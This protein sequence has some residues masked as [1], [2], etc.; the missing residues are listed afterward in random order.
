MKCNHPVDKLIQ[1]G[2]SQRQGE[3]L[4]TCVICGEKVQAR[5]SSGFMKYYQVKAPSGFE[6]KTHIATARYPNKLLPLVKKHGGQ[7]IFDA[8]IE[9]L[10]ECDCE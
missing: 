3:F 9:K 4:F 10:Q 8:G 2:P 1:R 7:K 6:T 5:K